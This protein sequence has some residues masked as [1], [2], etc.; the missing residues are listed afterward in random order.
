MDNRTAWSVSAK[1]GLL[2]AAPAAAIYL[3]SN[4]LTPPAWLGLLLW[5]VKLVCSVTILLCLMKNFGK[6]F[7][8]T[9]Y[10]YGDAF[11]YGLRTTFLSNLAVTAVFALTILILRPEILSDSVTAYLEMM[12]ASAFQLP[13]DFN[14]DRL[15]Q[16]LP[17]PMVAFYFLYLTLFGLVLSALLAN[18]AKRLEPAGGSPDEFIRR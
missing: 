18:G 1:D 11:R 12:Q 8:D 13:P 15:M 4:L 2:L 3:V 9:A 17:G 10:T 16:A 6:Q 14:Y 5:T 7:P